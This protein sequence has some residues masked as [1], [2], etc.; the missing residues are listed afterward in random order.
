MI[1]VILINYNGARDTIECI[2][3][4]NNITDTSLRLI[5]VDNKSSDNSID[6]IKQA[7]DQYSFDLL[8]AEE[9]NGF[10]SGNNIGIKYALNMGAEYILLLNNDTVVTA[11]FLT[12]L[13][14]PF[15]K[16][17]DCGAAISKIL[18]YSQ[19]DTIWYGGGSINNATGRTEHWRINEKDNNDN[20]DIQEVSFASGC[21]LCLKADAIK[22]VGFLNEDYF[23]YEEDADYCLR[24]VKEG[25]KI[26]YVPKSV[27]YHKVSASVG[28]GSSMSQY[29]L[30]RNKYYL[31]KLHFS[32]L[33]KLLAYGYCT[34]QLL[35]RCLKGELKLKCYIKGL[36]AFLKG[37]IGKA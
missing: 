22:K 5:I 3:S 2:E 33:N 15:N 27:I 34:L 23:L 9:N 36:K 24:M 16:Y 7:Q 18:Y 14:E 26:Y 12:Q 28:Q 25:F 21:C 32:K 31:I 1:A 17:S 6:L 4:L 30:V 20:S 35:F 29:Y 19:P 10:S 8:E 13:L 37:T 11:D